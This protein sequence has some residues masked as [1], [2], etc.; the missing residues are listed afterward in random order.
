MKLT[1]KEINAMVAQP[2]DVRYDYS[3]KRI[4]DNDSLWCLSSGED[5]YMFIQGNGV[6]LFPIWPFREYA[7]Q[8]LL[9]LGFDKDYRCVEI[10]IEKFSNEFV[11]YLCDT[12]TSI[13]IF[14]VAENDYGKIVSVNTFA[15]DL[16]V[17]L[18]NYI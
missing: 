15:E 3:L 4:A 7:N 9:T 16:S 2:S 13:G 1:D 14:P 12:G 17:E 18:E 5:G 6:K 10:G 11:D 8:Y